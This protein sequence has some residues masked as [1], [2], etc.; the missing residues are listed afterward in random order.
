MVPG[1]DDPWAAVQV[2]R[3]DGW[4]GVQVRRARP[5]G[6]VLPEG[7]P[8]EALSAMQTP[9][10]S[11]GGFD[12]AGRAQRA[13]PAVGSHAP[14]NADALGDAATREA[15][16]SFGLQSGI[17]KPETFGAGFSA[18]VAD[19]PETQP[20]MPAR[21]LPG[22][23]GRVAGA[24]TRL[25]SE[26]GTPLLRGAANLGTSIAELAGRGA[27]AIADPG[28]PVESG[29]ANLLPTPEEANQTRQAIFDASPATRARV[30]LPWGGDVAAAVPLEM[31]GTM[32][33]LGA[34]ASAVAGK[35]GAAG[36]GPVAS[37]VLGGAAVTPVFEQSPEQSTAG[38]ISQG[39]EAAGLPRVAG[40]A[41]T[42]SENAPLR[43]LTGGLVDTGV[44][45]GLEG[46]GAIQSARARRAAAAN[47]E[48]LNRVGRA[49]EEIQAGDALARQAGAD[50]AAAARAAQAEREAAMLDR[51]AA[52]AGLDLVEPA[53]TVTP[54]RTVPPEAPAIPPELE[55][56]PLVGEGPAGLPLIGD[57]PI[58]VGEVPQPRPRPVVEP[59]PEAQTVD[60]VQAALRKRQRAARASA[61]AEPPVEAPAVPEAPAA[62]QTTRAALE[63]RRRRLRGLDP[64]PPAAAEEVAAARREAAQAK[65]EA[66]SAWRVAN[67][68]HLTGIGNTRALDA[69]LPRAEADPATSVISFDANNFG[70]VNKALGNKA[71]DQALK[72]LADAMRGVTE[73]EGAGFRV[74]RR[75]G[76]EFVAL[77]PTARAE[78]IR[79]AMERAYGTRRYGDV[80]V[81]LSGNIGRTFDEADAGLQARKA[82]RKAAQAPA[83]ETVTPPP[84]A[85]EAPPRGGKAGSALEGIWRRRSL[86]EIEKAQAQGRWEL[87]QAQARGDMTAIEKI[88]TRQRALDAAAEFRRQTGP[89]VER[90]PTAPDSVVPKEVR[91]R[92]VYEGGDPY[93]RTTSNEDLADKYRAL[94][95]RVNENSKYAGGK[96]TRQ[97]KGA[98]GRA[99]GQM[100]NDLR[101]MQRVEEELRGRGIT[102]QGRDEIFDA[103]GRTIGGGT[104]LEDLPPEQLDAS[105]S[106]DD[107]PDLGEA[108]SASR[109]VL[110]PLA[111]GLAGGAIGAATSE[112]GHRGEGAFKGAVGGALAG[113]L[114]ATVFVRR[115]VKPTVPPL[116]VSGMY[117][118]KKAALPRE[119]PKGLLGAAGRAYQDLLDHVFA[120]REFGRRVGGSEALSHE[121]ERSMSW[122]G[123]AD[124]YL[125]RQGQ[126]GPTLA[127]AL[128]MAE[129]RAEDVTHLLQG[130]RALEL[131]ERAAGSAL[132]LGLPEGISAKGFDIDAT[133]RHVREL[134]AIPEVRKAADAYRAFYRNLLDERLANRLIS[135]KQYRALVDAGEHY[136]PF[137]RDYGSEEFAGAMRTKQSNLQRGTGLRDLDLEEIANAPLRDPF[138]LAVFDAQKT[139]RDIAR[140]R[141]TNILTDIIEDSPETARPFIQEV[142]AERI[143]EMTPGQRTRANIQEFNVDGEKRF[144]AVHD[145]DL[146]R[147]LEHTAPL[148]QSVL[149]RIMGAAK[150]IKRVGVTIVPEFGLTNAQK[151]LVFTANQYP[152]AVKQALGTGLA[153]AATGALLG[154]SD[155]RGM[156]ALKGFGFG[157]GAGVLAPHALRTMSALG[158]VL[159]ETKLMQQWLRDGGG[160]TGFYLKSEEDAV[161]LLRRLRGDNY[162][163]GEI[164]N[165]R[166]WWGAIEHLQGAIEQAPRLARYKYLRAAGAGAAEAVSGGHNVSVNFLRHGG[167]PTVQGLGRV[168]AFWNANLQGKA[169]LWRDLG[170]GRNAAG[171]I[172][173]RNPK[174][175]AL[176]AAAITAP[177]VALWMT[178]KDDPDYWNIPL[179]ERNLFWHIPTGRADG[180]TKFTRLAK[181]FELGYVFASLP[182]R[183][184]DY[185]HQKDPKRLGQALRQMASQSAVEGMVPIPDIIQ[186]SLE[187]TT[188]DRGYSRFTGRPIEGEAMGRL[189]PGQRSS[190]RTSYPAKALGERLNVSPT[191]IDYWWRQTTGTLGQDVADVATGVARRTGLDERAPTEPRGPL[192]R[193]QTRQPGF[194]ADPV[195][196]LYLRNEAAQQAKTAIRTA[197]T[198]EEARKLY[199]RYAPDLENIEA[200]EDAVAE[201]AKARKELRAVQANRT[202][203]VEER[204]KLERQI[205]DYVVEV[206]RSVVDPQG[207]PR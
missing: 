80:E 55:G 163:L 90:A 133:R 128:R 186:P 18:G 156:N 14:A 103:N 51:A 48:M 71:G 92:T 118:G 8:V 149:M 161:R 122:H 120:A 38:L 23:I 17:P 34:G 79:T 25:P 150:T 173:L 37:R 45:L 99:S 68:D 32:L 81:S 57:R 171:K 15:A 201:L 144:Y 76:D 40:V 44:G 2:K 97:N 96:N 180:H 166:T 162:S 70:K 193:F 170:V 52:T 190:E 109:R 63:E 111:G 138:A 195:E 82:A 134:A 27:R 110:A 13:V 22:N 10:P 159:G 114:A 91:G 143:K 106:P 125:G 72:E 16:G 94:V 132:Q 181:P 189:P 101:A 168:T 61:A 42:V 153:G 108:G 115:A 86:A 175:W 146:L 100:S 3:P 104:P 152:A 74:F 35:L 9:R 62:P 169:K 107:F 119:A 131:H 154:D 207:A 158:D 83:P 206:A 20:V 172:R 87:G 47:A 198:D 204:R 66:R 102:V 6:P 29:I 88:Q 191:K 167:D 145:R 95:D 4:Q 196:Q 93:Y 135:P 183:F 151:D 105:F 187:V 54:P 12:L 64:L 200:M 98:P 116:D 41:K 43:Y 142:S 5:T 203:P 89:V 56:L 65:L 60:Q 148:T 202:L 192:D 165:P 19:T 30:P 197:G 129:G 155:H 73:Q 24:L 53:P 26:V 147:S 59:I 113:H 69:A 141:V 117:V 140:Q 85:P 78:E 58:G 137:L 188:T 127:R 77:V 126:E 31:A 177:T 194:S 112:P 136:T 185:V 39:A 160:N 184:L 75:G 36:L 50:R 7:D 1:P 176:G 67:T 182:E 121:L 174:A 49:T 28:N 11:A 123:M 46:L 139:A 84:P 21:T 33:P 157:V 205:Q 199:E 124:T 164:I 130:E 179:W 178:N